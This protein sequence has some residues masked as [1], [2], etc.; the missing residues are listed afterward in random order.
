MSAALVLLAL[1]A[2]IAA[3]I[4]VTAVLHEHRERTAAHGLPRRIVRWHL[5]LAHHGQPVTDA[6][7]NRPGRRALTA[8]GHARRFHY[9]PQKHRMMIRV[10]ETEGPLLLGYGLLFWRDVTLG[11]L[12]ALVLAGIG[13]GGYRAWRAAQR[14]RFRRSWLFPL[15]QTLSPM[16]NIPLASRPES[17]LTVAHDRSS[18]SV[19]LPVAYRSAREMERLEAAVSAALAIEAP[20]VTWDRSGAKPVVTFTRALTPPRVTLHDVREALEAAGPDDIVLGLG[21]RHSVVSVNLHGDSPHLALSMGSGAGKSAAARFIAAQL[22]HK[23]GICLFIDPKLTNHPWVTGG[24][25]L[26]NAAWAGSDEEVHNALVWLGR[27]LRRRNQVALAAMDIEGNV[28]ADVGPRLLVVIEELN[29]L[30]PRL[31]AYWRASGDGSPSPAVEALAA[32]SAAGRAARINLLPI[33]QRLSAAVMGGGDARTNV[34]IRILGRYD[35]QAWNMLAGEF[36]MPPVDDTPGRVQVV[37][38][39]VT[40]CQVALLSGAEAVRFATDGVLTPCPAGMPGVCGLPDPGVT[41]TSPE[42][43]PAET[44]PMSP[45]SPPPGVIPPASG[46]PLREACERG[47]LPVGVATA[48]VWRRRYRDFPAPV[49]HDGMTQLFDP[50]ELHQFAQSRRKS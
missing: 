20:E 26:P 49:A 30:A 31:R 37:T 1:A 10:A 38:S 34:G 40:E 17:Y 21:K 32:V 50:G 8:T 15:H 35:P 18:A 6:G 47:I 3:G 22:M 39:K 42:L 5:G 29:L 7:W 28:R 41:G 14:R 13:Y 43:P 48:K 27:E 19:A 16:L 4:A 25:R 45:G 2:V 33:A 23:G 44:P 36:P 46:I 24:S 11:V 12:A 9:R